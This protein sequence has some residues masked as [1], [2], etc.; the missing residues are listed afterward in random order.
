MGTMYHLVMV[1]LLRTA[2]TLMCDCADGNLT[3]ELY[4]LVIMLLLMTAST[5]M[6]DCADGNLTRE[7]G[8]D[9]IDFLAQA[10]NR[11]L[12]PLLLTG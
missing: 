8:Q 3:M 7:D 11:V 9:R 6:C 1:V 2:S 10:R 4:H 12:E 5:L